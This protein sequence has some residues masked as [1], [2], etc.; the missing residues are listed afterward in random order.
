MPGVFA[1]RAVAVD[2]GNAQVVEQVVRLDV[3]LAKSVVAGEDQSRLVA[4]G[5]ASGSQ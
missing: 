1:V 2:V 5:R 3:V 4:E